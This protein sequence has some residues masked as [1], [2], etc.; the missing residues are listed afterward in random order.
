[1]L[2]AVLASMLSAA[3]PALAAASAEHEM[4]RVRQ[5]LLKLNLGRY[6]GAFEAA[7]YDDADFLIHRRCRSRWRRPLA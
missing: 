2:L 5:L 4:D 7:G 1:M 6:A 3:A